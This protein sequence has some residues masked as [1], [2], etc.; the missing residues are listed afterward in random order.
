MALPGDKVLAAVTPAT[1]SVTAPAVSAATPANTGPVV[2][3]AAAL[4]SNAAGST[5]SNAQITWGK[6]ENVKAGD[7]FKVTLNASGFDGIPSVPLYI[8]YDPRVLSFVAASPG[9]AST[10]VGVSAIDPVINDS[11]GRVNMTLDAGAGKFFAGSGEL[12]NLTFSAKMAI[13]QT[14]VQMQLAQLVNKG[15]SAVPNI[16][17]PQPLMLRI[18]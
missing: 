18:E 6:L 5:G 16:A 8:R 13:R 17:R 2:V 10:R 4:T 15:G 1:Q 11:A 3:A 9:Q 7:Q 12:V 14:Q